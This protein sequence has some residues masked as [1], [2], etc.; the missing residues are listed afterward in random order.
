MYHSLNVETATNP[1]NHKEI[2]K[3]SKSINIHIIVSERCQQH[4][5]FHK[6]Q[7]CP[8][9]RADKIQ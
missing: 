4:D 7:H 1:N 8:T 9:L 3:L 6:P 5:C 2:M